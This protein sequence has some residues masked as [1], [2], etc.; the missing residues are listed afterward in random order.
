M[1]KQL[2]LNGIQESESDSKV[3]KQLSHA[4]SKELSGNAIF[5]PPVEV[6]PRSLAAA[7]ALEPKQSKDIDEPAPRSV[8]TSVKIS[9]VS[10]LLRL[11]KVGILFLFPFLW[12]FSL[13][14]ISFLS[15]Q[16]RGKVCVLL[17]ELH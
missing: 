7:R 2:E 9:N 11:V 16:G 6:P 5:G 13:V 14:W 10:C 15:F 1:P 4:K 12:L 17:M 8:R 3:K